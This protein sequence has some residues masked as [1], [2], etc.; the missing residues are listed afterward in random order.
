MSAL[1]RLTENLNCREIEDDDL[2][3]VVACLRRG[4]PLRPRRYWE[5]GLA[6]LAARPKLQ[7]LPKY[8]YALAQ[9]GEIV[10]VLLTIA[11]LPGAGEDKVPRCNL[12]SW[13]A[14]PAYRCHA[15]R[16]VFAATRNRDVIFTNVS[17]VEKT[18]SAAP[19]FGFKRYCEGQVAF[20]PALSRADP[21]DRVAV[22][23]PG[24]E[25]AARLPGNERRI[26]EEHQA[27]GCQSLI[28]LSR[29]EAFPVVL[30]KKM[31]LGFLPARQIV[32]CRDVAD[33]QRISGVLGRYL[34]RRGSILC[35]ADANGPI[36]GLVGRFLPERGPKYFR[37]PHAPRLGDLAYSEFVFF[38]A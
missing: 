13:C 14:D 22:F 38:G 9:S 27:L 26:L 30:R 36:E 15:A 7:G 33:L 32:Y 3:G 29:G 23:R 28:C 25:E 34:L 5:R 4:F 37:G 20:L 12:S 19:A 16:L 10:G 17:P 2:P 1:G 11:S 35:I 18:W 8:G 24:E 21:G 6:R 31:L